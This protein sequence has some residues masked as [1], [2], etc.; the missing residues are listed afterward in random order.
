MLPIPE[1]QNGYQLAVYRDRV[2]FGKYGASTEID[3]N[4]LLELHI[5]ND[6]TEQ[7]KIYSEQRDG[8]IEQMLCESAEQKA[9]WE[10]FID[11]YQ[12]LFGEEA[13]SH[14][15]DSLTVREHGKTFTFF[16]PFSTDDFDKGI[17]LKVRN[18]YSY[19]EKDLLYLCGYRLCGIQIGKEGQP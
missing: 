5:F 11:D 10:F 3:E 8:F 19:D 7:R 18:Y 14:T 1:M 17:F 4:D 2:T 16:A 15:D 13:V 9:K 12:L 6:T